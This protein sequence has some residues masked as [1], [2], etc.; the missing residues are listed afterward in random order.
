MVEKDNADNAQE[1]MQEQVNKVFEFWSSNLKLPTIG[2]TYAFSKDFSSF[3][4]DFITLG[5]VMIELKSNMDSYW[6]LV[7]T[8]Y[9]RAMRNTVEQA[10]MQLVTKEDFE[11]HRR[12]AI[13]AF[14]DTF[15]D[16]FTSSEFSEV[17]GKLFA[18]QLNVSRAIQSIVEKNFKML[19]LPTRSEVDDIL[20]EIVELKRTVRDMKRSVEARND[21]AR[22]AT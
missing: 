20:K 18:S 17:Y 19:N 16:L 14:E 10:P 13:E 5:K 22:I 12:A 6:S 1:F 9:T 3:A 7:S 8:A 2:P 15:T 21:Q 4:N 11:N